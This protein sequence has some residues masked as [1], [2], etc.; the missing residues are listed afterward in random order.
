MKRVRNLPA[1]I[2]A[3]VAIVMVGLFVLAALGQVESGPLLNFTTHV[4]AVL[5]GIL[6]TLSRRNGYAS[7]WSL[8]PPRKRDP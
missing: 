2:L 1:L 3:V 4:L 8:R 5:L 7:G 6:G